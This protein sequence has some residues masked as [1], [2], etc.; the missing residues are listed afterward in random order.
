[1]RIPFALLMVTAIG[2]CSCP[3]SMSAR[4]AVPFSSIHVSPFEN[5]TTEKF[6][7]YEITKY[8]R[9]DIIQRTSASLSGSPL[10]AAQLKGVITKI[11][12][13]ILSEDINNRAIAERI[14]LEVNVRLTLENGEERNFT[15]VGTA[16]YQKADIVSRE[17]LL[18]EAL[19][20]ASFK[21]V[22]QLL[23]KRDTPL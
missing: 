21:V 1:M 15:V 2:L 12:R 8:I 7:G 17:V 19:Q 23:G 16:V 3:Y 11:G 5:R 22:K 6:L 18:R 20:D 4:L 14:S 9:T 13:D 10:D